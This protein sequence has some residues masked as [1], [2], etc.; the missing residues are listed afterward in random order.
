MSAGGGRSKMSEWRKNS[1]AGPPSNQDSEEE[2]EHK[3][4]I[5]NNC[6][7]A[8]WVWRSLRVGPPLAEGVGSKV[9]ARILLT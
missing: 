8:I 3:V 9:G 6:S 2:E 1:G 4:R 7:S 5:Q